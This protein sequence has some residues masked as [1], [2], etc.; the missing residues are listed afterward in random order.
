M[1]P[2]GLGLASLTHVLEKPIRLALGTGCMRVRGD[3]LLEASRLVES[4][5]YDN[6]LIENSCHAEAAPAAQTFAASLR[7][8]AYG[9]HLGARARLTA[10][11]TVVDASRLLADLWTIEVVP[12]TPDHDQAVA[13]VLVEQI[14]QATVLLVNKTDLVSP[15]TLA[16]LLRLL[17][18]LNPTAHLLTTAHG[19]VAADQLLAAPQPA[20]VPEPPAYCFRDERPFHPERLW[21]LVRERWPREVVRSRGTFWLAS[22]PEEVLSWSQAGLSRRVAPVGT[23][24]AAV[25]DRTRDPA[26]RRE[27]ATLLARWHP[28]FQDRRTE[29]SFSGLRLDAAQLHAR[30]SDCLCTPL[31]ISRWRRGHSFAD[32]WPHIA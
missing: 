8:P 25:P 13:D 19:Q 31:E 22:R 20:P 21:Q 29:L 28:V 26:Y 11:V 32:P 10:S 27:E 12:A 18:Q 24:W 14:E 17:R 23:W 5:V 2:H 4:A 7:Q 3:L 6:L 15:A 16:D 9:L 1:L 30:L